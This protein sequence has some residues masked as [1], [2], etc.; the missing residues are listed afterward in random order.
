MR[1][2]S[3]LAKNA[4][5]L[6]VDEAQLGEQIARLREVGALPYYGGPSP[7]TV[8]VSGLPYD[9]SETISWRASSGKT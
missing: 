7:D 9:E 8:R 1:K 6:S 2:I 3:S 5:E 4:R